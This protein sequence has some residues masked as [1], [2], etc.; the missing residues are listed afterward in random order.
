MPL[1]VPLL[2]VCVFRAQCW[3]TVDTDEVLLNSQVDQGVRRI[4]TGGT[5]LVG[6][7]TGLVPWGHL[8]PQVKALGCA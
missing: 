2:C 1:T 7:G 3:L 5:R 8:G 4:Q 6:D